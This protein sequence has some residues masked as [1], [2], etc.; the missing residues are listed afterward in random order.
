M[1]IEVIGFSLFLPVTFAAIVL[2]TLILLLI[3]RSKFEDAMLVQHFG[4]A[5]MRYQE[6]V[7]SFNALIGFKRLVSVRSK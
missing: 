5:A 1:V 7:P 4:Q 2:V 3:K 6:N